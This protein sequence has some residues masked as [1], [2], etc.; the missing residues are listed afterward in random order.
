[1]TKPPSKTEV[2]PSN[3]ILVT[4]DDFEGEDRK[5]MEEYIN[6]LTRE[7]LMRASTRTRQGVIIKPGSRPK[8]APDLLLWITGVL[9]IITGVLGNVTALFIFLSP[10]PTFYTIVRRRNTGVQQPEPY[11]FTLLNAL[12][13]LYYGVSKHNGLLIATIMEAIYVVL[14]VLYAANQN[15][16]DRT[17]KWAVGLDIG[18]SGAVLAVA[19]FAISQLELRIRVI[20]IICACFNVLMCAS[21]L[22]A[23]IN[24]IQ[25]ENVDAMPFWLSFFLF[26]NGGVWLVYGIIN[27]DML[28]GIPN[29]IGFLLGTIQLIVYAIYANFIHC[30]RLRL[31]LRGLVGRQALVAPLL[32]NA[33]EGQEA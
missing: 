5:T 32:P 1:M 9:Y 7:A 16:R 4:L 27:R 14:F 17:I 13:W 15:M 24:V 18:L 29:G 11:V 19:T 10:I 12:L 21:P 20:G 23:V 31:F 28:I 6:E 3:M 8:L 2:E 25:H 26:L 33:V 22:T 30:R